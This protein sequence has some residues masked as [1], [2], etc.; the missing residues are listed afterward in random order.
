MYGRIDI[1]DE[2]S[3]GR[4]LVSAETIAKVEQEMLED[5]HVTVCELSERIPE[6]S[7]STTGKVVGEFY[8]RST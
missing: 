1:R 2:Q 5:Q 4:P 8:I 3:S 7:K 6:V